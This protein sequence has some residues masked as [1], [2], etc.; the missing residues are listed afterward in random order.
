MKKVLSLLSIAI[1][2]VCVF[3]IT[4]AFTEDY[5]SSDATSS[6]TSGTSSSTTSATA[7]NNVAVLASND[8][9]MHC[10]CPSFD[11]FT[12]LPPFNTL[13]A[14]VFVKGT[15]DPQISTSYRVTYSVLE[16]TDAILK[17]DP[18]YQNWLKNAPKLFPGFNPIRAD[19]RIQGLTGATLSG[20]MTPNTSGFYE[21]KG[22][23]IYPVVTNT[24]K[25]IMIDPLGGPKRD[26]YLTW[27]VKVLDS[28]GKVVASTQN[29][30]PSAFGGCCSCHLKL[31]QSYGYAN[32]TSYD[33]FKVMGMLHGRNSSGIDLSY[34]DTDGDGVPGPI[35]CSYCHVD[36]AMGE[37]KAPGMPAG[38]KILPGANFTYSQV[39]TS[40]YTFSDV[41]HRFHAQDSLVLSSYDPNIAKNC[42]DCHPGNG[43]NCYRDTHTT[44]TINGHAIWCTD[45]HGDLNQRIS[46]GQLQN[47]WNI[48]TLP[49]CSTCHGNYGE[50]S[51]YTFTNVFGAFL[52]SQ[53][54]MG[55]CSSCHGSPHGL[56]PSTLAND[57]VQNISLQNDSRAIGK[58]SVCHTNE[59][60][61][62]KV[63]PH[64]LAP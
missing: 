32:P 20:D 53:T 58:C 5:S 16:N 39:K 51:T 46:S 2:M 57:N 11:Y 31:A 8:L 29:T 3:T 55:L 50:S 62:W 48:A 13:R 64:L 17:A 21:A 49:K 4:K 52:G 30:A 6:T 26:P 44:K 28:N 56:N 38:Y 10:V 23:P 25:D 7:S 22:V 45:C 59:G 35:R 60:N 27:V 12:V 1:A 15:G 41:L 42:Y 19:G 54:K 9:G 47:P 36:P 33:S 14:Q 37:S 61:T 40:K 34:L 18:Y 43:V 24:S 63:P